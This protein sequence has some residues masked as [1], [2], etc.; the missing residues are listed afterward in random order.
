MQIPK[1]NRSYSSSLIKISCTFVKMEKTSSSRN[2]G[3][4]KDLCVTRDGPKVALSHLSYHWKEKMPGTCQGYI[5][6]T[7][8]LSPPYKVPFNC[9]AI[10]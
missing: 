5:F 2:Q 3:A 8:R 4:G 6:L 9:D 1:K 10:R 7:T